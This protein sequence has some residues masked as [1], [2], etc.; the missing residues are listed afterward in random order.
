MSIAKYTWAVGAAFAILFVGCQRAAM[1]YWL[2]REG[3]N[4]VLFPPTKGTHAPE[5]SP[6]SIAIQQARQTAPKIVG[7]DIAGDL[8]SLHWQGTTAYVSLHSQS[9]FTAS[10]DQSPMQVD[11]GIYVD[12]LLAIEK[13]RVELADRQSKGCLRAN[14]SARL[15]RAIVESLPLPPA[16]AYFFQLGS[17][18][19][20]GYFD[21]TPDFRMQVTSPIYAANTTPSPNS[22]IGYETANYTFLADGPDDRARLR[23]T[24]ATE[25]LIGADPIEK[26][27]LRNELPFSKSPGYFRLLFLSDETS[28]GRIT[29]AILL[30]APGETK[31]TRAVVHRQVSPDDFCATL[32]IADVIC[33][34]FPKN[35]G[36][37]PELRVRV[38]SKEAFV[39]VGGIV[40]E[41]LSLANPE[42]GPPRSLKILRPFRGRLIPI[43]FDRSNGDILRVV[44]LPGDQVT[45]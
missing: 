23:L 44:L 40:Q 19:I 37:S 41:V 43:K 7:C 45:F 34:V 21:L 18:D 1:T 6:S 39:R 9:F 8:I 35:F 27:S 5:S 10:V 36:V 25:V 3:P 4:P 22:L 31:L 15:R 42:D 17:Y 12:P 38:N 20:T 16:V 26:R 30:S 2:H 11:R 29:R 28:S 33:T 24:S 14:E 32:F 13:F